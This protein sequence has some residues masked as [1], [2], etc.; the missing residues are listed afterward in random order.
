VKQPRVWV[1]AALLA[2]AGAALFIY[3]VRVLGF[4][5]AAD[6]TTQVW[7]VE[8]SV[9]FRGG[10][11]PVKANLHIPS[12]TPG[13]AILDEQFVSRR[14]GFTT[15]Y[16][17]GGREVQWAVRRA[18]GPQTLYYRATIYRDPARLET[19]TTPPFPAV[20]EL[21]EPFRTSM[22]ALLEDVR[23]QSADPSSF[24]MELL[25]RMADPMADQNVE[26]LTGAAPS[27]FEVARAAITVLAA[28]R[29]PARLIR[30]INLTDHQRNAQVMTWLEI[31]DGEKWLYFDPGTG[32][33]G[34]PGNFLLWWRGTAPL[35]SV[36]GG[37][38]SKARLAVRASLVDPISVA[39]QR[40]ANRDSRVVE[41]SLFGLP[42]QTQAVYA[43]LLLVPLGALVVVFLRNF[44]GINTFGTFM[45]VLIALAFR[46]TDL[47]SGIMLFSLVVAL[48]LALRFYLERLRLLLVPR[49]AAVLT[50]V[51][52]LMLSISVISHRLGIETGLSV[53]LFPMVILAMTIERM[54]VVWE[55][56]GART[57]IEQ[58]VGSLVVAA[59]AYLVIGLD[60]AE[61]LVVV[62]PELLLIVLAT[63]IVAGRYSGYRL[64]ELVRFRF[65]T[66]RS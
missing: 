1:L 63:A 59:I 12:L 24:T 26:L 48:G 42:I 5:V 3:K 38:E 17:S 34:L 64:S 23:E 65:L 66:E 13:F 25:K 54:S 40:A 28:A 32:E 52:L 16:V 30:G 31:H 49:L 10:P 44:V 19:D 61:H 18:R 46:E 4:P 35:V 41:Y 11:G 37:T 7:T 21:G 39:R 50:I 60:I 2:G 56:R 53:A 58:G 62:F 9:N 20:P 36:D 43:I 8:A 15:R 45:P 6:A 27:D 33:E 51:V 57:A 29:I 14:F 55:E 22:N 47:L